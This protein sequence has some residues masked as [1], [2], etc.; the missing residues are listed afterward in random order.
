MA[1]TWHGQRLVLYGH[2]VT[3]SLLAHCLGFLGLRACP[4]TLTAWRTEAD[5]I[6][7]ACLFVD[8]VSL[9]KVMLEQGAMLVDVYCLL[10]WHAGSP[11]QPP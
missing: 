11:R 1:C 4:G 9:A 3:C 8:L 5:Q 10:N 2:P 7:E 6:D